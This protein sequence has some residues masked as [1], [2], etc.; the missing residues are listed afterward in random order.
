MESDAF[1]TPT[2]P[3]DLPT[4]FPTTDDDRPRRRRSR[5]RTAARDRDAAPETDPAVTFADM[6][7]IRPLFDAIERAGYKY[8]TPVQ[9]AVIPQA[10]GG[11]DVIGQ[12]Q[13]GTGK[14]AAFL[15]PFLNRWRPHNAEG[16][17]R[18]RHVAR[19]ANWPLQVAERGREARPEQH[20]P[21]RAGVRRHR[22]AA[23][24]SNGLAPRL[25]PRRRHARP[26]ARPPPPR[27]RCRSTTSGTSSSTRPTGC[28]TSASAPTSSAS[29]A[30]ARTQRQTLLM[31]A[32]V[33]DA[34]KRLVNRYMTRPD[35]PEHVAG[36]A[37]GGQDPPDLLH[38]GRGPEV[39]PAAAGDRAREAAAV[40]DLRR[41]E[42]VGRQPVPQPEARTCRASR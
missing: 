27:R 29:S 24:N 15:I 33:P 8:A 34:I 12:A 7:L 21:H 1:D 22:H 38:R 37:D 25:R 39:R 2:R 5:A 6:K 14:T 40:P 17:D 19:P 4:S 42:A 9:E 32:T 30:A 13:T 16:A 36:G 23:G 11:R 10:M 18:P 26:H 31:S 20:V 35:P 28:S 41:A 3:N